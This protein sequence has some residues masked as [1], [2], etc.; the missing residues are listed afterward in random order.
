MARTYHR[1]S[2]GRFAS[3]PG[4]GAGRAARK[5]TRAATS[6]VTKAGKATGAKMYQS[7]SPNGT[8]GTISTAEAA[9]IMF[10]SN[11][12]SAVKGKKASRR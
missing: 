6:T 5:A 7:I 10:G 4:G 12:S 11:P 3:K 1:D 8:A 9:R 2:K